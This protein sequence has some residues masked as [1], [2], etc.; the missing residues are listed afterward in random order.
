MAKK[1]YS[2]WTKE[3]LNKKQKKF[4]YYFKFLSPQDFPQFFEAIK[5]RNYAK[6]TSNLE[7][8]LKK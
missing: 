2:N 6:Y 5:S 1:D 8:E 7:A 3:E 4:K